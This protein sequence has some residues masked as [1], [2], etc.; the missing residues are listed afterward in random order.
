MNPVV[1]PEVHLRKTYATVVMAGG[2]GARRGDHAHGRR[3]RGSAGAPGRGRGLLG[4]GAVD[5]AFGGRGSYGLQGSRGRGANQRGSSTGH[6]GK[7]AARSEGKETHNA[8][9][10]FPGRSGHG[11]GGRC[12]GRGLGVEEEGLLVQF[13]R[14][15]LPIL[16]HKLIGHNRASKRGNARMRVLSS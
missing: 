11:Q 6:G 8:P 10:S 14:I 1:V 4:Q 9:Q 2:Q 15:P 5:L 7:Q 13:R 16:H 3:P 12:R